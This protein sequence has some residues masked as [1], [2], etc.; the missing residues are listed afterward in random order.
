MACVFA[1][2]IRSK[3][4][5]QQHSATEVNKICVHSCLPSECM[6]FIENHQSKTS[7]S[8]ARSTHHLVDSLTQTELEIIIPPTSTFKEALCELHPNKAKKLD[9]MSGTRMTFNT[10]LLH[11]ASNQI[12]CS[13]CFVCYQM[14]TKHMLRNHCPTLLNESKE[15]LT[16]KEKKIG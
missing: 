6:S 15:R 16:W 10:D 11:K 7:D 5:V 13:P 12:N 4:R 1:K 14:E 9:L 3:T 8:S 2:I